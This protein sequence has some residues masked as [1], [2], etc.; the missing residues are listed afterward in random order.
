M[1]RIVDGKP[2]LD[3]VK[4]LILEYTQ[5]LNRDLSF[6]NLDKELADIAEKYTAPNGEL[7][8]AID[9]NEV[10][11]GMVAYYQHSEARCEMKRL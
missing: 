2:Y 5:W 4:A 10:V 11:L 7:L 3:Q 8:V 6:Q 9:D 1:I